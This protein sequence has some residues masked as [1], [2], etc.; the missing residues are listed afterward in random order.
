M[1]YLLSAFLQEFTFRGVFQTA[2]QEF[3]QDPKGKWA[4]PMTAMAFSS[5]HVTHNLALTAAT[6][7]VSMILGLMFIRHR[8]L[9][10]VTI[11]HFCFGI[12]AVA[13]GI[14]AP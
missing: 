8:S 14:L 7:V 13:M 9:F 10:G 1:V 12:I 11:L 4:V 5:A 6:L 3:Y 2:V